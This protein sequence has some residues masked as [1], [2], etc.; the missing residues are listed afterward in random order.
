MM[1]KCQ[2]CQTPV[3][4]DPVVCP[5][6]TLAEP[7]CAACELRGHCEREK[8]IEVEGM[9]AFERQ[10][11]DQAEEPEGHFFSSRYGDW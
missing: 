11:S 4:Q 7:T 2:F 10:Q 8:E 3:D 6:G 5:W 1:T 9:R